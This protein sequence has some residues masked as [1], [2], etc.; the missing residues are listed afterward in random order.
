MSEYNF[1]LFMFLTQWFGLFNVFKHFFLFPVCF[2]NV[3]TWFSSLLFFILEVL[4][5]PVSEM[6]QFCFEFIMFYHFFLFRWNAQGFS[7][8][9]TVAEY[10]RQRWWFLNLFNLFKHSV[11]FCSL[12][13]LFKQC[14]IFCSLI[15]LFKHCVIFCSL[16]HL[17]KQASFFV[18]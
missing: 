17:F 1:I 8:M 12:I 2:Q 18:L 4:Y 3:F 13:H 10:F 7:A 9:A 14:V 5:F 6:L 16:I 11:V 15:H